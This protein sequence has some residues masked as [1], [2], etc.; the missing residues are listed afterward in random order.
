MKD[1]TIS[2]ILP[3]R[4]GTRLP[5]TTTQ[6]FTAKITGKNNHPEILT[7]EILHTDRIPKDC[8]KK[9]RL[10]KPV[11]LKWLSEVPSWTNV[12]IWKKLSDE[13]KLTLY[14]NSF[15][16]GYGVYYE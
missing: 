8:V 9:I 2:I 7:T 6:T 5:H 11:V 10:S 1:I 3:G 4:L 14:V 15:D 13:Q 16:E 12:K